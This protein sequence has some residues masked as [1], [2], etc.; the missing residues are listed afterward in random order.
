MNDLGALHHF[1]GIDVEHHLDILNRQYTLDILKCA[2][3]MYYKS[4]AKSLDT[5]ANASSDIALSAT[6]CIS[7]SC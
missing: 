7:Q 6:H 4:C 5:Q 3:M 1:L 2:G